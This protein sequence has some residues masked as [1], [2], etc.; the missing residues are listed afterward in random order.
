MSDYS[1]LA[2]E[3]EALLSAKE[4]TADQ[5]ARFVYLNAVAILSALREN[6]K[7]REALEG[8]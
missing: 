6:E 7:L 3:I 5:M 4:T 1:K 8:K 2:D